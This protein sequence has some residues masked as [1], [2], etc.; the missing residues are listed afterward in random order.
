VAEPSQR[1]TREILDVTWSGQLGGIERLL[2]GIALTTAERDNYRHQVLFLDGSGPVGDRLVEAK[3]ATRLGM[4][5]GYDV[6]GLAMVAREL[7]RRRP[8]IIHFHTNALGAYLVA[9]VA[10]PR[11]ARVY[12]E[13]SR[14]AIRG[15]LKFRLLYWLLRRTTT[16][17]VAVSEG[18]AEALARRGVEPAR[19]H[20]VANGTAVARATGNRRRDREPTVGTVA[21]LEPHKRVDL[22]LDVVAGLRTRGRYRGLVVGDGSLRAELIR[23]RDELGLDDS[24]EFVG[25]QQDVVRWLDDMDVFLSASEVEPFGLAALEAMARGVPVVAMPCPGGLTELVERG[26]FLLADREIGTAA[27]ALE[28]LLTSAGER[29]R[30]RS[31]GY[32]TAAELS[33]ARVIERLDELY[34]SLTAPTCR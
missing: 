30:L 10:V 18:M 3:R 26:G 19:V 5:V 1:V 20:V 4:R 23:R 32:T 16:A 22:L 13:H 31:R 9:L 21:R 8:R 11:A 15:D 34:G 17:F 12:T 33:V 27:D 2:E 7:R 24:V 6:R 28:H 14:R 29:E 25:D